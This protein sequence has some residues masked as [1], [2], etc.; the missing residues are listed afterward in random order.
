[1]RGRFPGEGFSAS[2]GRRARERF[3]GE[4]FFPQSVGHGRRRFLGERFF[5]RVSSS[6]PRSFRG[7]GK[8]VAEGFFPLLLAVAST[9]RQAVSGA[10]GAKFLGEGFFPRVSCS[11]PRS[12]RGRGKEVPERF[13]PLLS[14]TRPAGGFQGKNPSPTFRQRAP[15]SEARSPKPDDP[16]PRVSPCCAAASRRPR[17]RRRRPRRPG[18]STPR[19][20]RP[21]GRC[22]SR[23][24]PSR[25]PSRRRASR[26]RG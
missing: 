23:T 7:R 17:R 15:K 9:V 14:T 12:F 24:S 18:R 13:F 20:S 16:T 19:T 6:S 8:E 3:L 4:R 22:G 2:F 5:P 25:A 10:A 26:R 1:M 11:S 21:C